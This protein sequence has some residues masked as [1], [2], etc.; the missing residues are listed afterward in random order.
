MLYMNIKCVAILLL[1]FKL[2]ITEN[3]VVITK[4]FY[5]DTIPNCI[6]SINFSYYLTNDGTLI[7]QFNGTVKSD[8]DACKNADLCLQIDRSQM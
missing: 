3:C 6:I 8:L 2:S 4:T 7:Y 5:D 1:I